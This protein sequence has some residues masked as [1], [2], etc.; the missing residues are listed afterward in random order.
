VEVTISLQSYY[1]YRQ[2]YVNLYL[3]FC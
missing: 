3:S 2:S 1:R